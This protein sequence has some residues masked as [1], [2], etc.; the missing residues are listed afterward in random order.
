[1][2]LW[3]VG[4]SV[5][6]VWQVFRSPGFDYRMVVLGALLPLGDAAFGGPRVLHTLLASLLV[7][8]VVMLATRRRRNRSRRA[9]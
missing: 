1:M 5:V 8:T 7:L 4:G 6:V 3:F 9:T 2:F